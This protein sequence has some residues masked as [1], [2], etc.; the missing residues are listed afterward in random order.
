MRR[1]RAGSCPR[2]RGRGRVDRR[3]RPRG[4][5][6]D[7]PQGAEYDRNGLRPIRQHPV[8]LRTGGAGRSRLARRGSVSPRR[9][10]SPGQLDRRECPPAPPRHPR[11]AGEPRRAVARVDRHDEPGRTRP[12]LEGDRAARG[13]ERSAAACRAARARPSG[14]GASAWTD[15]RRSGSQRSSSHGKAPRQLGV[16]AARRARSRRRSRCTAR[17]AASAGAA[18]PADRVGVAAERSSAAAACRASRAG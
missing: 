2:H 13:P 16:V 11:S 12:A 9:R 10:L 4:R 6:V 1:A 7:Q 3:A 18:S 8:P 17:R 15:A 14:A 5:S